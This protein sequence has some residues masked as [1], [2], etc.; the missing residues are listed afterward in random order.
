MPAATLEQIDST[1]NVA[2]DFSTRTLFW[3]LITTLIVTLICYMAPLH[4][5]HTLAAAMMETKKV[6]DAAHEMGLRSPAETEMDALKLKVSTL[7]QE[8][9]QNSRSWRATVDDFLRGRTFVLL[10]CIYEVKRVKRQI[11]IS[12]ELAQLLVQFF[13]VVY[14]PKSQQRTCTLPFGCEFDVLRR[15][16]FPHTDSVSPRNGFENPRF[17]TEDATDAERQQSGRTRHKT[18]KSLSCGLIQS[19]QEQARE[20]KFNRTVSF[21]RIL[22]ENLFSLAQNSE[23]EAWQRVSLFAAQTRAWMSIRSRYSGAVKAEYREPIQKQEQSRMVM[24]ELSRRPSAFGAIRSGGVANRTRFTTS[25]EQSSCVHRPALS[26]SLRT[27]SI[28]PHSL[29]DQNQNLKASSRVKTITASES[30]PLVAVVGATGGSR[31]KH[32]QSALKSDKPHRICGFTGARTKAAAFKKCGVE[33]ITALWKHM[34]ATIAPAP[35]A[36]QIPERWMRPRRL[37]RPGRVKKFSGSTP[38]S[39][40]STRRAQ[41]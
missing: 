17:D 2:S 13:Q 24:M 25:P 11:M 30:A 31:R 8:T 33:K 38:A 34:D 5:A 37:V 10:C 40:I 14:L 3:V 27:H 32:H 9:V 12:K 23:I 21:L 7:V 19:L 15:G 22:L 4:L 35:L 26:S 28:A 39:R 29:N 16:R 18:P 41:W 36:K 6:Y 20:E 1:V